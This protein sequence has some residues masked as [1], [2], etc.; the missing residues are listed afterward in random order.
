MDPSY[1]KGSRKNKRYRQHKQTERLLNTY[2]TQKTKTTSAESEFI[3]TIRAMTQL[4]SISDLHFMDTQDEGMYG[5]NPERH[6]RV[7]DRERCGDRYARLYLKFQTY[8]VWSLGWI[9]T[10]KYPVPEPDISCNWS[11]STIWP[12]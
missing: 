6:G 1:C 12:L 2:V 4:R 5:A 11:E 3:F 10:C 9:T 7:S 8:P